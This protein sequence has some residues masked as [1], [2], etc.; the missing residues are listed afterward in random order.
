MSTTRKKGALDPYPA[1]YQ[2]DTVR[3]R[4][5]QKSLDIVKDPDPKILDP[6]LL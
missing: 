5:D 1:G 3:I 2:V 6:V 4:L